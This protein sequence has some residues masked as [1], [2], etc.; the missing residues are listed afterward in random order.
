MATLLE[1]EYRF[2]AAHSL[3]N[4]PEGHKC[5]RVH[6]HSYRVGVVVEGEVGEK[7]GWVMDFSEIDEVIRPLIDQLDHRL[8]NDIPGL[9]NPT[10]ELLAHWLWKQASG[11]TGLVEV[12]VSETASSRCIYR[13][14]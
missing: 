6:G 9:S 11:L 10:S 7:T 14:P 8:L 4:V 13:G 12:S 1:R 5:K 3:P 2:E